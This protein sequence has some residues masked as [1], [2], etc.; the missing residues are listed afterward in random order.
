MN[1][2]PAAAAAT[3]YWLSTLTVNQLEDLFL[4]QPKKRARPRASETTASGGGRTTIFQEWRESHDYKCVA[5]GHRFAHCD[6]LKQAYVEQRLCLAD[7]H[8]FR[9]NH[10]EDMAVNEETPRFQAVFLCGALFVRAQKCYLKQIYHNEKRTD[11]RR[12]YELMDDNLPY[13]VDRHLLPRVRQHAA[14]RLKRKKGE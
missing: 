9:H 8:I 10:W 7:L 13:W 6:E 4:E 1:G 2:G 5:E 14:S 3:V 12:A 11:V